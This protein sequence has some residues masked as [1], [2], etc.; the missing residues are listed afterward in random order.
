MRVSSG[1]NAKI[2]NMNVPIE[3]QI[4]SPRKPLKL[5]LDQP[6]QLLPDTLCQQVEM[7]MF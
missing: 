2:D 1:T 4:P 5:Q 7:L 3:T 6:S